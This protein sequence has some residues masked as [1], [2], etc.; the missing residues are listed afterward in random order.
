[1]YTAT[2]AETGPHPP[3]LAEQGRTS[4][5]LS[6]APV[7]PGVAESCSD[8]HLVVWREGGRERESVC[9]CLCVCMSE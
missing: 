7:P 6:S 5:A 3:P 4:E 9:V 2:S 8:P 1:M